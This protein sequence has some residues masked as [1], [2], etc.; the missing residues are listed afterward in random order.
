MI[1]GVM[2][3]SENR[4]LDSDELTDINDIIIRATADNPLPDGNF[5][6]FMLNEYF[7][8]HSR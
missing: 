5:I 7:K 6:N 8:R 3:T 2:E 4:D 1:I